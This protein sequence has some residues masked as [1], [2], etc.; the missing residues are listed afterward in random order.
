MVWL[1]LDFNSPASAA[2]PWFW[3]V[4]GS[5]SQQKL[6]REHVGLSALGCLAPRTPGCSNSNSNR[7]TATQHRPIGSIHESKGSYQIDSDRSEWFVWSVAFLSCST[8]SLFSSRPAWLLK[9]L[10]P[11]TISTRRM[12]PFRGTRCTRAARS[13]FAVQVQFD[14]ARR[15]GSAQENVGPADPVQGYSYP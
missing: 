14:Q 1:L 4:R 3:S 6:S 5:R 12:K 11:I 10:I 9:G 7:W 13:G 2:V 8:T 15:I